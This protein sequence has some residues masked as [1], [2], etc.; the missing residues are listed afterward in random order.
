MFFGKAILSGGHRRSLAA[1]REGRA[2][3]CA[4]DAVCV[5]LARR[6]APQDLEGLVEIARSPPVPAL[7]YVTVGGDAGEL[8]RALK[9]ACEDPGLARIRERLLIGGVEEVPVERYGLITD[10]EDEVERSGGLRLL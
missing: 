4:I 1:V 9:A 6:Y 8:R 10:Y 5:E 2:D 7:P 3:V